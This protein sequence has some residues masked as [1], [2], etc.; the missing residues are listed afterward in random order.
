MHEH[1]PQ[2]QSRH[3]PLVGHSQESRGNGFLSQD[4]FFQTVEHLVHQQRDPSAVS[5]KPQI[6]DELA[7]RFLVVVICDAAR[8]EPGDEAFECFGVLSV[9]SDR[10]VFCCGL[11]AAES[12]LEVSRVKGQEAVVDVQSTPFIAVPDDDCGLRAVR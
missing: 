10:I 4:A 7:G 1:A 5:E 3:R 8:V 11:S 2:R 9:E 6:Y 12:C